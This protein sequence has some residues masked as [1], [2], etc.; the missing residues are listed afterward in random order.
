MSR[1]R[2]FIVIVQLH[3]TNKGLFTQ[4]KVYTGPL[5]SVPCE[6]QVL[7]GRKQRSCKK[8]GLESQKSDFPPKNKK[9]NSILLL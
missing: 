2:K 5:C 6:N 1:E 9:L 4:A 8:G 3:G 7:L